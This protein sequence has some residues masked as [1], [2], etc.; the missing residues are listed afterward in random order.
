MA[1][2]TIPQHIK[3]KL[4]YESRYCCSICQ[5]LS[6]QIHHIDQNHSNN[7]EENLIVLCVAH[8][9]EAHT[10]R[11]MS[12][13]LDSNALKYAKKAWIEQVRLS[14][15][16]AAT[17]AGQTQTAISEWEAVGIAWGYINHR[18]VVQLSRISNLESEARN[19]FSYCRANR[20]VDEDG[21]IV[22]PSNVR[23]SK[24]YVGNSVYDW[25]EFGDDQR[26][27]KLYSALVDQIATSNRVVHLDSAAWTKARAKSLLSDGCFVYIRRGMYFKPTTTTRY[28]EQRRCTAFKNG[29]HFEFYIDTIDMFGTTSMDIS[30]HGHQTCSA[31]LLVKSIFENDDGKLQVNCTP[32]ALGI[33]FKDASEFY[34]T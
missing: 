23:H 17:L 2:P 9:N 34:L 18:R 19:V 24:T 28:N 29:V 25:F 27:H 21:I 4:L 12:S 1:R 20:I 8:H 6:C 7:S 15:D 32:I 14:R 30:F 26:L 22:K 3:Q 11:T 13:N 10:M 31:L 5:K 33:G 16:N